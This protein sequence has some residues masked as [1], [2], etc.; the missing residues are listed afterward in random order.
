M[1]AACQVDFYLLGPAAPGAEHLAC[2]LA[3]MAWERGHV[4]DIVSGDEAQTT[5]LDDLL[6]RYPPERFLP[7]TTDA[8]REPAPIRIH[9]AAP[10]GPADVLINLTATAIEDPH[11]CQ[12]LLEIV[13]HRE[14]ER[15][16]S[17]DKFRAYRALGL[18][19]QTHDIN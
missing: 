18:E 4:I 5:A 6:W 3:L 1:G 2:R 10:E 14:A 7:H 17:R 13:P 16:A 12:R 19:P 8:R 11:R 9:R 15:S